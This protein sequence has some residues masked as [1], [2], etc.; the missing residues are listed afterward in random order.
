MTNADATPAAPVGYA[1]RL[2]PWDAAMVVVGGVI[3]SGIFLTPAAVARQTGS[4][5][6]LLLAWAIGGALALVGAL[7]YAELGTRRP[8]AG[9]GYVNLREA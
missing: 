3:G 5:T 2:G 9:G 4:A 8:A 6:E 1:R 7:C